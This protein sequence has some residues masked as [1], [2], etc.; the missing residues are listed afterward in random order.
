VP[1]LG[2]VRGRWADLTED[3]VENLKAAVLAA[4]N[5]IEWEPLR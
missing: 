5:A 4:A 3:D 2:I 1:D